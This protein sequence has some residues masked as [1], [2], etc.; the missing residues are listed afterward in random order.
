VIG[1]GP[2]EAHVHAGWL[3][4]RTKRARKRTAASLENICKT[5]FVPLEQLTSPHL[6]QSMDNVDLKN[7]VYISFAPLAHPAD[8][9]VHQPR[10]V[11]PFM[12]SERPRRLSRW[13]L[14]I[15][16]T[17]C[18]RKRHANPSNRPLHLTQSRKAA[19]GVKVRQTQQAI[20]STSSNEIVKLV[21][22]CL[23]ELYFR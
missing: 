23:R 7:L 22:E 14:F 17:G 2:R 3:E 8:S 11:H 16:I 21:H 9:R 4:C 18:R 20:Q 19:D 6:G 13:V 12:T 1:H 5:D 10:I 15:A